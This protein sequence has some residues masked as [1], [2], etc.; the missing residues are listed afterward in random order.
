[1]T[2]EQAIAIMSDSDNPY[3]CLVNDEYKKEWD[4]SNDIV[5]A[6]ASRMAMYEWWWKKTLDANLTLGHGIVLNE[7]EEARVMKAWREN[8]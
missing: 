7:E 2:N 6:L 4:D 1:M 3:P 8:T 5:L